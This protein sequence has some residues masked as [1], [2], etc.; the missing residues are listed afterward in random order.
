M[1]PSGP[2][3]SFLL[4]NS[5]FSGTGAP[6][7]ARTPGYV[8][9]HLP[10]RSAGGIGG[11]GFGLYGAMNSAAVR[12]FVDFFLGSG[13]AMGSELPLDTWATTRHATETPRT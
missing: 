2:R 10:V 8:M 7:E 3:S 12:P 4:R 13:L 11:A 9:A 6:L 5:I 1:G